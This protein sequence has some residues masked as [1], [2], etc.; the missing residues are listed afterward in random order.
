MKKN[1][2]ALGLI[3]LTV[4][5]SCKDDS[6]DWD[7]RDMTLEFSKETVWLPDGSTDDAKLENL[8]SLNHGQNLQY[9]VDPE[10]GRDNMYCYEGEGEHQ[11]SVNVPVAS[12][13]TTDLTLKP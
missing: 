3:A 12:D 13:W 2:Y 6:Y 7:N 4:V 9:I 1:I 10:T 11:T 8:F 5:T